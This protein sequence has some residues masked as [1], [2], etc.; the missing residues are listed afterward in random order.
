MTIAASARA[1]VGCGMPELKPLTQW[2]CDCCGNIIK[3]IKDAWVEWIVDLSTKPM[4]YGDFRIVHHLSALPEDTPFPGCQRG[5]VAGLG[6]LP[7][8]SFIGS[9]GQAH[10]LSWIDP[11]E[12]VD[13]SGKEIGKG[14]VRNLREWTTLFRRIHMPY[15]EEARL[16]MA[17][18]SANG[19]YNGY[20]Q[21]LPFKESELLAV[22]ESEG[23]DED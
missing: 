18:A 10:L 3:N 2:Y 1:L 9:Y 20:N 21:A 17:R 16:Y 4:T 8:E 22:I 6:D 11:G 14:L 5:R 15:Y 19:R 12:I 7:M 13:P 23:A